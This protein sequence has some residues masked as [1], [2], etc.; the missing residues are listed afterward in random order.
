MSSAK[1][2]WSVKLPVPEVSSSDPIILFFLDLLTTKKLHE[3]FS[4][5]H[6]KHLNVVSSL[7]YTKYEWSFILWLL[8]TFA[9][10]LI[11]FFS[12]LSFSLYL[13]KNPLLVR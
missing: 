12:L 6:Q 3:K 7:E 4:F 8:V 5:A 11:V 1:N 13:F 10:C 9:V 2:F